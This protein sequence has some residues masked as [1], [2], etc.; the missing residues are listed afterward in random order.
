ME[1]QTETGWKPDR[2]EKRALLGRLADCQDAVYS[3]CYRVLG[4]PQDAEDAAQEAFV[5]ALRHL[6]AVQ[7]ADRLRGWLYRVAFRAALDARRRR[8]RAGEREA[9]AARGVAVAPARAETHWGEALQEGLGEL[10]DLSRVFVVEYYYGGRTLREIAEERGMSEQAVWKR[11]ER[12]KEQLRNR[13]GWAVAAGLEQ[14]VKVAAPATLLERVAREAGRTGMISSAVKMIVVLAVLTGGASVVRWRG[15]PPVEGRKPEREEPQAVR[16]GRPETGPEAAP[17]V[18]ERVASE[19]RPQAPRKPYPLEI[20]PADWTE[21]MKR[22]W[23][24]LHQ[25]R[26]TL[27]VESAPVIKTLSGVAERMNIPFRTD[28]SVADWVFNIHVKDMPAASLFSLFLSPMKKGYDILPDG[29]LFVGREDQVGEGMRK[30][31]S[32]QRALDE[33]DK[34][35]RRLSEGWDG[36][37][38]WSPLEAK[39]RST[40]VTMVLREGGWYELLKALMQQSGFSDRNVLEV[41]FDAILGTHRPPSGIQAPSSPKVTAL[42]SGT[43]EQHL[44]SICTQAGLGYFFDEDRVHVTA[45]DRAVRERQVQEAR[46]AQHNAR[47]SSLERALDGRSDLRVPDFVEAL[48]GAL[49][50]T[51]LPSRAAWECEAP[52]RGRTFREGLDGLSAAGIRWALREDRIYLVK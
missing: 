12:A 17:A 48:E 51:V 41:D 15:T 50:L 31:R 16:A 49:R 32:V 26:V 35:R 47:L 30:L 36:R 28:P 40:N 20:P 42:A 43:L 6:E 21:A 52:V 19:P 4:H 9:A 1:R 44:N 29:S 18:Q 13:M 34:I 24:R 46:R 11:I 45:A 27:Q 2:T 22:T 25:E 33:L 38:V 3:I 5:K 7:D 10:D 14:G 23:Q 37:S 8:R 39:A